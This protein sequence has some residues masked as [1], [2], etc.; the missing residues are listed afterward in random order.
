MAGWGGGDERLER[1]GESYL[2]QEA[3]ALHRFFLNYSVTANIIDKLHELINYNHQLRHNLTYR[4]PNHIHSP[5]GQRE[6][7]LFSNL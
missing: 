4:L 1:N 6:T 3:C 7:L 2:G 5:L